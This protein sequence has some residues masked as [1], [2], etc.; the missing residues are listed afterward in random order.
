MAPA[1]PPRLHEGA[2]RDLQA[3]AGRRHGGPAERYRTPSLELLLR[4]AEQDLIYIDIVRLAHGE[5]HAAGEAVGGNGVPL[6][7]VRDWARDGFG[8]DWGERH[9][10]G[11]VEHHVHAAV[12][13]RRPIDER[14]HLLTI[15]HVGLYDRLLAETELVG[16]GVEPVHAAS[17]EH[18]LRASLGQMACSLCPEPAAAAGDDD[19]LVLDVLRHDPLLTKLRS[20][21]SS[22]LTTVSRPSESLLV[23]LSSG[24]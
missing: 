16:Q 5:E 17:A 14:L 9:E 18:D 4:R 20:F 8:L 23:P 3:I 15:G 12:N 24:R 6:V 22:K 19:D 21:K 1:A 10:T 2:R 13:L 11:V 7:V